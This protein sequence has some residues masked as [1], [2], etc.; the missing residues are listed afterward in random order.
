MKKSYLDEK[1]SIV[2]RSVSF[3][4]H[5]IDIVLFEKLLVIFLRWE[6]F[7]LAVPFEISVLIDQVGRYSA[8]DLNAT[9]RFDR[10]EGQGE[11]TAC[12]MTSASSDIFL[13]ASPMLFNFSRTQRTAF[14]VPQNSSDR[15]GD[16][17]QRPRRTTDNRNDNTSDER[18]M[19]KTRAESE[20]VGDD[21]NLS[22]ISKCSPT[23]ETGENE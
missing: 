17:W 5:S 18:D 9:M 8:F 14:P 1:R 19:L 10:F 4:T 7:L 21:Q 15:M 13:I 6:E 22:V 12:S 16:G 20:T 2:Q 3:A 23:E 11:L